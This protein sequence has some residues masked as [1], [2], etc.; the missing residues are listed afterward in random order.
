MARSLVGLEA[1]PLISLG[2][3]RWLARQAGQEVE[4]L[5]KP[6]P[7]QALAAVGAAWS[8]QETVAL[9]AALALHRD[10]EL[11]P[12]LTDLKSVT[13]HVFEDTTGGLEAAERG[14]EELQADRWIGGGGARRRGV[15]GSGS[16]RR[17]ATLWHH[18]RRRPQS[19]GDGGA[20]RANLPIGQR[21]R[22]DRAGGGSKYADMRG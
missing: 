22:P 18:P 9:E 4:R 17:V 1:W 3:I 14:V 8:G 2:R 6:C 15:A 12:P 16:D 11:R 20:G 10:G 7:V 19:S 21:G 13:L 5:I